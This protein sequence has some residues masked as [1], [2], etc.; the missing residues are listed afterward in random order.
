RENAMR[1][2]KRTSATAAAL[3]IGV[4]LVGLI[5]IFGA[6]ARTS[7]NAAIDQS[8]K[9]DY[10]ATSGGF[11]E[12]RIPVTAEEELAT[13]SSMQEVSG[14]RTGMAEVKGS[15][16][17]LVAV[18]TAKIN[19]LFDLHVTKGS[20]D[21]LGTDSIAVLDSTASDENLKI[22]SRVPMN[23]AQTGRREFTVGAIYRQT[24]VG[25]WVIGLAAY[26]QNFNDDFV[27][28]IY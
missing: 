5:T 9:A 21:N 27:Y 26:Q 4:A 19:S 8:M 11:G 1:N 16:Q 14:I 23:F 25:Q 24:Y 18:D 17:Q 10:V 13:I 28:Q 3:M 6:S 2:P 7:V 12:G 22:G 20:L 15:V